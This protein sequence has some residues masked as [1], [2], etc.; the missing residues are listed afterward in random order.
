M[1]DVFS[2]ANGLRCLSFISVIRF[3]LAAGLA[4]IL[5]AML[6]TGVA[7]GL[8]TAR[9]RLPDSFG[10]AGH[11]LEFDGFGGHNKGRYAIGTYSGDFT[12]SESR[13]G[14]FDPLYT[15]NSGKSTF[16]FLRTNAA[17][18]IEAS[19]EFRKKSVTVGIVTFDPKKMHVSCDFR[20][21]ARPVGLR[22]GLGQPKPANM[23]ERLLARST[24]R[25]EALIDD[26]YYTIESVHHYA[27]SKLSSQAP[28]GYT[29]AA[30]SRVVGALELTDWNPGGY[31]EPDLADDVRED[32]L[33]VMLALAVIR[34][35][36]DSVLE[37]QAD[38][39]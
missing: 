28:V 34:D 4:F 29:I 23:K 22:F 36:A 14:I 25:G 13:L 21:E 18:P 33:I 27:G 5:S 31:L 9:M 38:L 3:R 30:D 10:G 12:R 16:T 7:T 39:D 1:R 37:D 26:R 2:A 11:R 32:V 19:C 15:S 8:D 20:Q 24:R 35:P 17:F 6:A